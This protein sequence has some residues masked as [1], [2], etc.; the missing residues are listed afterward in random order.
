MEKVYGEL[1]C[2]KEGVN[3]WV[4]NKK[5]KEFEEKLNC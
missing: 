4:I 1:H 5:E 3:S 2:M